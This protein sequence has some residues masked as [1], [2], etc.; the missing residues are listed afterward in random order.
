MK[1]PT[2][3]HQ[4]FT[5]IEVLI[6]LAIAGLVMT[7]VFVAVPS[8]QRNS[9]NTQRRTD[10]SALIASVNEYMTHT[11]SL[12]VQADLDDII[13]ATNLSY[14]D[15]SG[16][17]LGGV[18]LA[19]YSTATFGSWTFPNSHP[20][21]RVVLFMKAKCVAPDSNQATNGAHKGFAVF[22]GVE[23]ATGFDTNC[24]DN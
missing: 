15:K 21:D 2:N 12:P 10:V 16:P 17:V 1:I 4:G 13:D 22:Y 24:V 3:R 23:T 20:H 18:N 7:M 6:V 11:V 9:R 5:I 8:L 14:Y 19:T